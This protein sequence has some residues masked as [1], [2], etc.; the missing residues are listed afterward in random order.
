ML[1]AAERIS[2]KNFVRLKAYDRS[3]KKI[4][5]TG[6]SSLNLS[7]RWIKGGKYQ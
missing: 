3:M 4:F 6:L 5:L 2:P 1:I 7:S